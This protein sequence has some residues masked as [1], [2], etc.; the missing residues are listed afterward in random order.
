MV[1]SLMIGGL[2]AQLPLV[3]DV[4]DFGNV[5]YRQRLAG[6]LSVDLD[7]KE[8]PFDT[9][10]LLID[11][12]SYQYSPDEVR[13]SRSARFAANVEAFSVE[14]W[15]FSLRETKFWE[16]SVP[17]AGVVRPRMTF[18]L[19]AQRNAQYYLLTMFLPMSLIVFMSWTAFWIQPNIVPPRI[20]ISTASIFSLS[21]SRGSCPATHDVHPGGAA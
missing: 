14:G 7:L 18:I 11:V 3:V 20:A 12:I 4:D 21:T 19:E 8:F 6:E 17:A 16:F 13:F 1:W 10:R 5:V 2:T 15:S 9:Q